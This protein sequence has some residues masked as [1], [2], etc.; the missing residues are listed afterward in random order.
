MEAV[1]ASKLWSPRMPT[2]FIQSMSACAPSHVTLPF[3]QCHHTRG[4]ALSGGSSNPRFKSSPEFCATTAEALRAR[5]NSD[6]TANFPIALRGFKH[7][8][9]TGRRLSGRLY[10]GLEEDRYLGN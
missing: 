5:I 4:R 6:I 7:A 9:V 1:P 3:I 2:R 8:S 10:G